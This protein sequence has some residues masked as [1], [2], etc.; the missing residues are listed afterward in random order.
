[1]RWRHPIRGYIA[2]SEFIPIAERTGLIEAIG[3]WVLQTACREA[4]TWPEAIKVSVN[5]SAVQLSRGDILETVSGALIAA[6]LPPSRL[7]LELTES[8]LMDNIG[9]AREMLDRIRGLGVGLS[10]D[11]FGTGYSS[12]G[13]LKSFDIDKVKIDRSFVRDLPQDQSSVAIIR[14]VVTLAQTL[15][16]RVNAEGVETAEQFAVLRAIGCDE[17][18]GFLHGRPEPSAAIAASLRAQAD[19]RLRM[20]G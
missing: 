10:L 11:D 19:A 9:F 5:L 8:I 7:D 14:A 2:P 17:V 4:V 1:M 20:A 12:L 3:A 15:G 18:Q 6:G 16:L 13:Y